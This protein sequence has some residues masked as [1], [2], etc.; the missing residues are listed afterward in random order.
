MFYW[1]DER[2]LFED[3][4]GRKDRSLLQDDSGNISIQKI[5]KFV[6]D[7]EL[8]TSHSVDD[9]ATRKRKSFHLQGQG[10]YP[11]TGIFL[12]IFRYFVACRVQY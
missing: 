9:S 6:C 4:G 11:N 5:T 12:T 1:D 10:V 8:K 2:N 3:N 7:N